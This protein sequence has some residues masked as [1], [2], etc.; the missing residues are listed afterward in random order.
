MVHCVLIFDCLGAETEHIFRRSANILTVREFQSLVNRGESASLESY[1]DVHL[2]AVLLKA[3]L[4]ELPEPILTY[5][6][7]DTVLALQ[8]K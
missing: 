6:L 7:Y 4:R 8:G 3:F 5:P 1:G 2:G